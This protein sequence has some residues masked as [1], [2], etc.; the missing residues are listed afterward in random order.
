MLAIAI[1]P[2]II[3]LVVV[4]DKR[5]NNA[6]FSKSDN[7][8]LH[9]MTNNWKKQVKWEIFLSADSRQSASVFRQLGLLGITVMDVNAGQ[10][11]SST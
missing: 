2:Q 10:S 5:R 1:V 8:T 4:T 7:A 3:L 6:S 11:P 9:P